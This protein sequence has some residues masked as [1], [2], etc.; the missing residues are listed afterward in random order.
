[1]HLQYCYVLPNAI[2]QPEIKFFLICMD[3]P[4]KRN[5]VQVLVSL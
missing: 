1:M 3:C 4:F 5:I 2:Q